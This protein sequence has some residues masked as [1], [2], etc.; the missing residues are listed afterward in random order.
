MVQ[1]SI[2]NVAKNAPGNFNAKFSFNTKL[3]SSISGLDEQGI[4]SL[5]NPNNITRKIYLDCYKAAHIIQAKGLIK[6]LKPGEFDALRFNAWLLPRIVIGY[7][8][9]RRDIEKKDSLKNDVE[10]GDITHFYNKRDYYSRFL[11]AGMEGEHVIKVGDD[12]YYGFDNPGL[13]LNYEDWLMTIK[14]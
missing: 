2:S 1:K 7:K 11:N 6:V 10:E 4:N 5:F 3:H 13:I 8:E 14:R 9:N 12:K